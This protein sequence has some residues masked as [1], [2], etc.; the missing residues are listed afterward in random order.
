MGVIAAIPPKGDIPDDVIISRP[1]KL[2]TVKEV[3]GSKGMP[4]LYYDET[5]SLLDCVKLKPRKELLLPY[6]RPQSVVLDQLR[7]ASTFNRKA[8]QL[9]WSGFMQNISQGLH[10][11]KAKIIILPIIDLNPSDYSCIYSTLFF[12]QDQARH[13]IK[14]PCLTFDQPLWQ[15]TES[16]RNSHNEIARFSY[17]TW[18]ISHTYAI[19]W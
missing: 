3:I 12:V 18:W 4:I 13:D 16:T 5:K 8:M 11:G 9:M 7:A 19:C 14:T 10:Q 1:K 17:L 2:I 6:A 15:K